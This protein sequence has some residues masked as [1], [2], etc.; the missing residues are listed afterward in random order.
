LVYCVRVMSAGF[1][2]PDAAN[3]H[4]THTIHQVPFVKDLLRM[5][6]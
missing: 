1:T 5:S 4:N 6:K 3:W 2:N